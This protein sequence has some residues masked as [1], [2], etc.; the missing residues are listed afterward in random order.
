MG[1][2]IRSVDDSGRTVALKKIL[3]EY[4]GEEQFRELFKQEA[5]IIFQLDHPNIVRAYNFQRVGQQ[6]VLAMEY[7]EGV[8]LRDI[9]V[10]AQEKHFQIPL[11]VVL[12]IMKGLLEG[13][14][15]AH[16]K[17]DDV[18]GDHLEFVHRD[19]NPSNVFVTFLGETKILDFG[20]SKMCSK[21][22]GAF[23][24]KTPTG[25]IRGKVAYLAPEQIRESEMDHRV[26]IFACGVLLWELLTNETLFYRDSQQMTL[27]AILDGNYPDILSARDDLPPAIS[28][29]MRK[30]LCLKPNGRFK[31]CKEF[32]KALQVALDQRVI[33]DALDEDVSTFVRVLFQ[34]NADTKEPG[35]LSGHAYLL[36]QIPGL[37]KAGIDLAETLAHEH[38]DLPIVQLNFA[39]SLF[40]VGRKSEGLRVLGSLSQ[41]SILDEVAHQLWVWLGVRRPVVVPFLSR[42][43]AVNRSL[44]IIRHRILGPTDRYKT[45][46]LE[47]A[48]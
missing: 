18:T 19:I 5:E 38:P 23:I 13:L 46:E 9:L 31:S 8:N 45:L 37:E 11:G 10:K 12:K 16:S 1:E 35:F 27:D 7:L 6:L 28:Q 40:S 34:K 21:G 2:I 30:A 43:N 32:A 3:K 4:Q 39:R 17:R 25:K 29:V 15:Y 22:G 20:I 44:G 48:A 26:D 47:L 24:E 14:D 36:T 42:R 33:P 41:F